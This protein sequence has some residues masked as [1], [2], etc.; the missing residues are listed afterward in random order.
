MGASSTGCGMTRGRGGS[1][2]EP[3]TGVSLGILRRV[4]GDEDLAPRV[5]AIAVSE[6]GRK[7]VRLAQAEERGRW[8][9]A[10]VW[11]LLVPL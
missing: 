3:W 2:M 1:D 6:G 9:G 4:N 7:W 11:L 10:L 8:E 5:L